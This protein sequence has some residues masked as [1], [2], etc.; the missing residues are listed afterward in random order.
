MPE[1]EGAELFHYQS[2]WL[3]Q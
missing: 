3:L 1:G 2:W